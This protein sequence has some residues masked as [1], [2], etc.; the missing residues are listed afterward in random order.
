MFYYLPMCL[1]PSE[2]KWSWP[3][4]DFSFINSLCSI[5]SSICTSLSRNMLIDFLLLLTL[6]I[7][8][9]FFP[10]DVSLTISLFLIVRNSLFA[11]LIHLISSSFTTW[12]V[13]VI[14]NIFQYNHSIVV[15]SHIFYLWNNCSTFT[16][17]LE[18]RHF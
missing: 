17:I 4:K 11:V 12:S 18:E 14:L 9:A 8:Q 13:Q 2:H 15:S 7:L 6:I 10:H 1:I 3:S 5:C 16:A